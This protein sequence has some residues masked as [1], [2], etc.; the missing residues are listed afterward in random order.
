M[1][2][3][4]ASSW[5][6]TSIVLSR[7]EPNGCSTIIKL[8]LIIMVRG[9]RRIRSTANITNRVTSVM[10]EMQLRL[11]RKRRWTSSAAAEMA[12]C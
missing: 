10:A 9:R 7:R 3:E 1:C 2:D 11:R 12:V 4:A 5:P 6:A 8:F